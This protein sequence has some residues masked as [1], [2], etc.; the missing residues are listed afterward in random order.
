MF[1][2]RTHG[3]IAKG[4]GKP[5]LDDQYFDQRHQR[6][7][8]NG[9]EDSDAFGRAATSGDFNHDGCADLAVGAPG[10]NEGTGSLTILYGAAHRPEPDRGADVHARRPL[11]AVDRRPATSAP[12]WP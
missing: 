11:F 2:G 12:R 1:Y 10:E 9:A 7:A 8:R 4:R 5:A 6:R 3:L